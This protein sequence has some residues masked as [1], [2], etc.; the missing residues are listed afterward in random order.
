[1]RLEHLDGAR[2]Y[3]GFTPRILATLIVSDLWFKNLEIIL[4][5]EKM[6][7][8]SIKR[9]ETEQD[10][11]K[12]EDFKNQGNDAM[13]RKEFQKA[14]DSYTEAI[15]I[16]LGNAVYRCNRS[17]ASMGLGNNDHAW[18][19]AYVAT[20]LDPKYAKAWSRLG[21]ALVKE[22]QYKRA[23]K[24][25][26]KAI[27][28]AGKEA[29]AAMRQGLAD[30]EAKLKETIAAINSET[31]QE[32]QHNLH[33]DYLD[34]DWEIMGKSVE[35]HS[36]VHEQQVEG[37]LFFAERMK[38]PYINEVRDYAEDVYSNLR[39]G[40]II[41]IHLH[42]WLFGAMLPGK[43]FAFKL[44]TAL[45]LCTPSVKDKVGI[46][47][48]YE[49]GFSLPTRS[50]WRCR[51]VLGSVLGCIPGVVQMGGWIGPCPRVQ[52][53]D[54][55]DGNEPRHIRIKTRRVA[56]I[57]HR[58]DDNTISFGAG[59]DRWD[60]TRIQ[61]DEEIEPY[62]AEMKDSSK[63]IIPEPPVRDVGTVELESIQ[64]RTLPLEVNIALKAGDGGMDDLD[65]QNETQYR[66]SLVFKFD[67]NEQPV[68]YK[69]FTNPV[70]ISLPPCRS[71]QKGEHEVHMREL[72]RYQQNI[73]SI[74]RLKDHTPEDFN[75]NEVMII[76]ATGKGA[77]VLARAWC[78]ERGKHA[79]IRR[80]GGPC[81]VC[82]VRAASK[83]SLDTGVLIWVD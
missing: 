16:D 11:M 79:A 69:L 12:A 71:N 48:Y 68:T 15:K 77:E 74:D 62:L 18:E 32:K 73:W 58:P 67:N 63:W 2:S 64:L 38:W 4:T 10:R 1:M 56:P 34:Q 23:K 59:Y 3:T 65:V 13:R 50:Y 52:F 47:R 55:I 39:G 40:T 7:K 14:I 41:N 35:L 78:S 75:R 37:L 19:D 76:N 9:P 6:K 46:A 30:A 27:A 57:E 80:V 53:D 82:A 29:T 60:A 28:V 36:R 33:T 66:A 21:M 22:G 17:A 42:D 31:D 81:F 49:C 51:T 70:F 8:S 44:M 26:E 72:A 20:Q 5:D 43:F 61:A 54:S 45:V 25:Y 83:G 24:T